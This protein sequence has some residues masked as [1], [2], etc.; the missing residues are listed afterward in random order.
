[1]SPAGE[2][3]LSRKDVALLEGRLRA[4]TEIAGALASPLDLDTLLQQVMECVTRLVGAERSTLFLVDPARREVWSRV[5]QR[6]AGPPERWSVPPVIRVAFGQGFAG[7]VAENGR[8]L[9]TVDA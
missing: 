9:R 6:R 3:A 7:W 2:Q 4:V 5:L 1:M 8:P